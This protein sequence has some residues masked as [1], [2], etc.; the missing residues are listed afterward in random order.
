[1]TR[2]ILIRH[3]QTEWNISGRYQGQSDVALT[4]DGIEQAK[5][6]SEH[7]PV[8]HVD[9]IYASNLQRATRTAAIIAEHF[10]LKVHQEA[11]F[12]E[13][14]FG[15]WEG[16]TYEEI[17]HQWPEAMEKFF[18][19]PDLLEIPN[20]ETFQQVQNRAMERLDTILH[21]FE[22][23]DHTVVVVAHGAILRTILA[24]QLN[25]SLRYVWRIRQFNTAVNIVR[26]DDGIPTIELMN[27]IAHLA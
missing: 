20:G 5:M 7:F 11:V 13:L 26:Y 14:S 24:A 17:I 1:M 3:G 8:N 22:G 27:S 16:L 15:D 19:Y 18:Q 4:K 23:G 21:D 9:A 12:R 10:G 6:L 25:M 2:L